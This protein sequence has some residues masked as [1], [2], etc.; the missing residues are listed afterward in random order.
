MLSIAMKLSKDDKIYH[1][2]IKKFLLSILM[3][4][5]FYLKW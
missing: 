2:A 4:H 1:D 3:K 5:R